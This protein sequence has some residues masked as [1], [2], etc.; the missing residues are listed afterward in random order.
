MRTV[1]WKTIEKECGDWKQGMVAT[2]R[3]YEGQPTDEVDEKG[4]PVKVTPRTFAE[5]LGVSAQAFRQWIKKFDGVP[6]SPSNTAEARNFRTVKT[7]AKRSPSAVVDAIQAAGVH[8]EDQIFAE[9]SQ[10]RH[11]IDTSPAN[12]KA[13][14]AAASTI[15]DAMKRAVKAPLV[16]TTAAVLDGITEDLIEAIAE[17]TISGKALDQIEASARR[18]LDTVV[19][20]RAFVTTK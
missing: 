5:H 2:F 8:A 9:L 4:K 16:N 15:T 13:A 3:K 19:S 6:P 14:E 17:G 20:G 10:R 11:G 18:L 7:E 1:T 12:R